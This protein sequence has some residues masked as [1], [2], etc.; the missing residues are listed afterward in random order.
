MPKKLVKILI[1]DLGVKKAEIAVATGASVRSIERW[2]N[3][4]FNPI[5][6]FQE[7]MEEMIKE[8]REMLKGAEAKP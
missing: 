6:I 7:K 4:D 3:N 2:Y 1:D 8:R 5:P